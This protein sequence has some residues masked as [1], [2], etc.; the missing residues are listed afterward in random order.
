M[1]IGWDLDGIG[2]RFKEANCEFEVARGNL[3]RSL[4]NSSPEW[5]Y[6]T[7]WGDLTT[8]Q[9]LITYAEGVDAGYILWK[10]EPYPDF[11][12]VA[13]KFKEDG[14]TNVVITDRSIGKDP[15]GA[16][17][18]WLASIEFPYDE[19]YFSPDKTIVPTDVFIEDKRENADAL[20]AAGTRCYLFNRSWNAPFDDGRLRVDSLWQF[21]KETT[22]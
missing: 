5:H 9:W 2:Y 4:E 20:N 6:Y 13:R 15:Q 8:P 7:K 12:D 1:R 21:Y 22:S 17:K 19:I 11:V 10:G 3:H 18:H 14:H 16:T